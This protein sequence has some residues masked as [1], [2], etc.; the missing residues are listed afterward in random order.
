MAPT[1][2]AAPVAAVESL[3][4]EGGRKRRESECDANKTAQCN[5]PDFD[6]RVLLLRFVGYGYGSIDQASM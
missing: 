2:S 3:I 5:G 6:H 4:S 1:A